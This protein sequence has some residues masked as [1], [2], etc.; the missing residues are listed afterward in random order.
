M[1]RIRSICRNFLG[2]CGTHGPICYNGGRCVE[3]ADSKFTCQCEP[4][5]F[6]P[7]C[8]ERSLIYTLSVYRIHFIR[9]ET[10]GTSGLVCMNS[11]VC[12]LSTID[13]TTYACNC[14]SGFA[15][16]DCSAIVCGAEGNACYNGGHCN[17]TSGICICPPPLTSD[18]CRGSKDEFLSK[19]HRIFLCLR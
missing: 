6:G 18:D 14:P 1:N 7:T 15:G 4:P 19:F 17:E 12:S 11:G 16:N 13:Q 9:I 8:E 5:W 10:C 2:S 3:S